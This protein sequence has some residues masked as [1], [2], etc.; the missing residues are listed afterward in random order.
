MGRN[1]WRKSVQDELSSLIMGVRRKLNGRTDKDSA[2]HRPSSVEELTRRN[3]ETILRLEEATQAKRDRFDRIADAIT[4]FCGSMRF[5]VFHVVWYTGW[6]LYNTTFPE[7]WRVDPFPFSFLTLVVS[8]EAIFLSTFILISQKR[9][10]ALNDR[11]AQLDLQV[12]LLSE[13]ENTKMLE[14]LEKIGRQ[15]GVDVSDDPEVGALEEATRPHKLLEQIDETMGK[16]PK[17]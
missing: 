13:Q 17:R 6:I 1:P 7:K 10:T 2:Y 12:N 11:R 15:V 3:V 5:V 14:L 4:N 8:L 16:S 9:E